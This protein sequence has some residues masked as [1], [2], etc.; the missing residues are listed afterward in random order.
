MQHSMSRRKANCAV[1]EADRIVA[2]K[3]N[4]SGED[5]ALATAASLSR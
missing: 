2:K 3:K 4:A 1:D 5:R